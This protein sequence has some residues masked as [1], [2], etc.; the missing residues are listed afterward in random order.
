MVEACSDCGLP[1]DLCACETIAREQQKIEVALEKRKFGKKYTV[2]RGLGKGVN[3]NEIARHLKSK[4]ACGG[5]TKNNM[6]ELQGD[7]MVRV[8]EVLIDLGFPAETIE[9]KRK[10]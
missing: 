1:K 6:I 10:P 8:K 4:L 9:I 2:V 7:H 5:T 3:I